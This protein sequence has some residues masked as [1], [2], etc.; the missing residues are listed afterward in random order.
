MTDTSNQAVTTCVTR[1]IR[2]LAPWERHDMMR[3]LAVGAETVQGVA[4]KFGVSYDSLRQF[5]V[6]HK[7]ELKTIAADVEDKMAGLWIAEKMNR[8]AGYQSVVERVHDHGEKNDHHLWMTAEM[9]AY[10]GVAE[11]LGQLPPRQN[12]TVQVAQHVVH[13]VNVEDYLA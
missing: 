1:L 10:H 9:Q 12:I 8:I 4:G 5:K 7:D 11:E 2:Q 6:R 3:D 13:G